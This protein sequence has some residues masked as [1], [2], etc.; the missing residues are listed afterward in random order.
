MRSLESREPPGTR[1][2]SAKATGRWPR[3]SSA[4]GLRDTH[5]VMPE[6]STTP[7]LLA[8]N[9]QAIEAVAR[10]DFDAAMTS[11]GPEAVWDTSA[12]GLGTYRGVEMIRRSFEEW[13]AM[14]EDFAVEIEE[15]LDFGSG[16]ILSV[17]RQ[18]GRVAGSSGYVEFHYAA[19][20]LWTD[21]LIAQVTPFTDINE[22]RADAERLAEE[23]A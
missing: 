1:G 11:Y 15:H 22:A 20:T 14:Y 8:L 2:G 10:R 17:T 13:T 5:R 3:I 4:G 16:V 23:R 21:G 7:D 6:E 9:R 12:L 19:V 18:R